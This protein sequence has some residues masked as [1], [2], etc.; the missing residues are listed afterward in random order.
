MSASFEDGK[1]Y[2]K[3][4]TDC[5]KALCVN[6]KGFLTIN[7]LVKEDDEYIFEVKKGGS[8]HEITIHHNDLKVL[9]IPKSPKEFNGIQGDTIKFKAPLLG[10]NE[11]FLIF[12]EEGMIVLDHCI[13]NIATLN[14][15][16]GDPSQVWV[17]EKF[18]E[19]VEHFTDA[20]FKAFY[21]KHTGKDIPE[22]YQ[23]YGD[24]KSGKKI[25]GACDYRGIASF[26]KKKPDSEFI[27]VRGKKTKK[28]HDLGEDVL[29][30]DPYLLAPYIYPK[31][32]TKEPERDIFKVEEDLLTKGMSIDELIDEIV[33][34]KVVV[35]EEL[36]PIIL[37]HAYGVRAIRLK[38]NY[39]LSFEFID[40]Y[41][42]YGGDGDGG[43]EELTDSEYSE[44]EAMK[45]AYLPNLEALK[46][47]VKK[48]Y[49]K[50]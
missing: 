20:V 1:Y 14:K 28:I 22:E 38:L 21:K 44:A 30:G 6:E 49:E 31:D 29:M 4:K 46:E 17:F 8:E 37:A 26:Y 11:C 16:N 48:V 10:K 3:T 12:Q 35:S 18:V 24:I 23:C 25:I 42:S 50:I 9:L 15:M 19:K 27:L 7:D 32:T 33:K 39:N 41:S 13:G 45:K 40:Y 36:V 47:N 2:I 43:F 5:S 34:S